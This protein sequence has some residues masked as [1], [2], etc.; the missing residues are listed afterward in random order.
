MGEMRK[1]WALLQMARQV[2]QGWAHLVMLGGGGRRRGALGLPPCA[3]SCAKG[4]G[5]G[6]GKQ[7][8]GPVV[9]SRALPTL[10]V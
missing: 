6:R 5:S 10:E 3:W 7:G 4:D 9:D 1:D 2:L 8:C